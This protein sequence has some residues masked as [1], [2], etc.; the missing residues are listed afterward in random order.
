MGGFLGVQEEKLTK[1]RPYKNS[2][3][4]LKVQSGKSDRLETAEA[5]LKPRFCISI[6]ILSGH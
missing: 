3:F 1:G 5:Q 6:A 4:P 2:H